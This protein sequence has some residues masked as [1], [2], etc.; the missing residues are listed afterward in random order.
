MQLE[1]SEHINFETSPELKHAT[2]GHQEDDAA[3]L[4]LMLSGGNDEDATGSKDVPEMVLP[5]AVLP[6]HSPMKSVQQH[7]T[8]HAAVPLSGKRAVVKVDRVLR[9]GACEGC[10][11]ADCGRCPN[12]RDK[13]KFGGAGVKKQ[14]CQHR[15]CLQPTRTGGGQWAMRQHQMDGDS[16]GEVSHSDSTMPYGASS[17]LQRTAGGADVENTP[18]SHTDPTPGHMSV[19]KPSEIETGDDA[20]SRNP[21]APSPLSANQVDAPQQSSSQIL[22]WVL[23]RRRIRFIYLLPT[24]IIFLAHS[25]PDTCPTHPTITCVQASAIDSDDLKRKGIGLGLLSADEIGEMRMPSVASG[26]QNRD[27]SSSPDGEEK[28]FSAGFSPK[29]SRSGRP[30]T[31]LSSSSLRAAA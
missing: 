24:P 8:S 25:H 23:G 13:P 11:R 20:G 17:P 28:G 22:P 14:A 5:Q 26:V 12:C 21:G 29:R 6:P 3:A 30:T 31:Q 4:L 15:R 1:C 9:C 10:R 16:D 2:G 7:T 19:C 27:P 18:A